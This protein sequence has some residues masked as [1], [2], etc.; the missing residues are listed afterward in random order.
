MHERDPTFNNRSHYQALF[1]YL[2]PSSE[3][4]PS[5]LLTTI[6]RIHCHYH[7]INP[8]TSKPSHHK[9]KGSCIFSSFI[10]ISNT[11]YI[12]F[13]LSFHFPFCL[14]DNQFHG[15]LHLPELLLLGLRLDIL[16]GLPHWLLLPIPSLSTITYCKPTPRESPYCNPTHQEA[17]WQAPRLQEQA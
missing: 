3:H 13:Q 9:N 17:A 14:N 11:S 5:C 2:K 6:H 16:M 4:A 7:P 15:N 1:P 10:N 12:F 8:F